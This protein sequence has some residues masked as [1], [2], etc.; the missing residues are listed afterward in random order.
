MTA[1][2]RGRR[3]A[4]RRVLA[5]T[6][7][8]AA[9][10]VPALPASADTTTRL[11]PA[12]DTN[13]QAAIAYSSATF[14]DGSASTVLLARD[15]DF[16]DS[17][18]SGSVQGRLEAPLLLTNSDVLSPD[19]MAEIERL[20]PDT[21][22]IMGGDDAVGPTVEQTLEGMGRTTDRVFGATRFETAIAVAARFFPN[23]T[24]ALVARG[25]GTEND[26]S[27]AFADSITA[28]NFSAAT[29][30]PIL[31][32]ETP[33][34]NPNT[35]TYIT[36]SSIEAAHIVGGTDAVAAPV[37]TA[38]AAIDVSAKNPDGPGDPADPADAASATLVVTRQAGFT[39]AD[40]AVLLNNELGYT[41]AADA[42]RVILIESRRLDA[43]A[44]GL[45]AG[46][47]A[48]NGAATLLADGEGLFNETQTFLGMDAGTDLICGPRVAPNA[49]T[50]A[51]TALGNEG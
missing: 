14:A 27:Q 32:T 40:T 39:R 22:L 36:G 37:E 48:G 18:T 17:L 10:L 29:Q 28:G 38:L 13:T 30:Q 8:L 4:T 11:D 50:A 1:P 19:T 9:L 2:P 3:P 25:F 24:I 42:P 34:L 20:D 46:A 16:A 23:A 47:Q 41:T 15:D 49:C 12:A 33:T 35:Q 44:S 45:T 43:W 31:L 26:P 7:L 5:G 6:T 21:V 51:S